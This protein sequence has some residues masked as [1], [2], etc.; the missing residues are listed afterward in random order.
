MWKEH[1]ESHVSLEE[2]QVG[3]GQGVT[4]VPSGPATDHTP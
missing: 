2:K 4:V 3:E 1:V